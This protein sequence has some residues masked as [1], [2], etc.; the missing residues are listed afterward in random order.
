MQENMKEVEKVDDMKTF[1]AVLAVLIFAMAALAASAEEETAS[2]LVDSALAIWKDKGKEYALK[3]VNASAGRLKKG[4]FYTFAVDFSGTVVGHPMQTKLR[5]KNLWEAK[6][7]NGKLFVQDMVKVA[8]S[9]EG[10]GWVEYEW[11]R[12]DQS[13]MGTKRAL[14][15]RVPGED[16]LVGCGYH[17]K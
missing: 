15:K 1:F 3:V 7:P 11:E 12:P 2:Q 14:I 6:D 10:S 4:I 17:I 9:Q 5:G 13:G 8:Q 16:I